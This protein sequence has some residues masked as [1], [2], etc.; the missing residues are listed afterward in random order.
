MNDMKEDRVRRL[1]NLDEFY[2]YKV[3]LII[4]ATVSAELCTEQR[5]YFQLQLISSR[6]NEFSY[7]L[8]A[9]SLSQFAV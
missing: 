3:K 9:S 7:L 6:L 1:I 2:E 8:E 5:Q 4:S